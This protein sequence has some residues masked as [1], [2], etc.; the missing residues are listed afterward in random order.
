MSNL[1]HES[2]KKV[3]SCALKDYKDFEDTEGVIRIRNSKKD[4]LH[5]GQKN[6]QQ[7]TSDY[8]EN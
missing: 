5:S 4:R 3:S 8:T 6:K 2:H 7:S 1:V